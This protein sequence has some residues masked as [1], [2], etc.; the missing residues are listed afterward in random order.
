MATFYPDWSDEKYQGYLREFNL[1]ETK[2]VSELSAGMKVKFSI[3]LALSHGAELLIM[4]EPTSGLDPLSREEFCDMVLSLK[5]D[6]GIT[7]LFSTHITSD[8]MRIADDII[9]IS[10][11]KVM[12]QEDLSSLI[13]KY[14][15]IHF[16][17]KS[18]APEDK[19]LIGLKKV[20]D[21]YAAL[22]DA[23]E[24]NIEGSSATIDDIIIHLEAEKNND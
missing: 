1:D 22:I 11:G 15:L 8:L 4:D 2:K 16:A 10:D 3:T 12:L 24:G 23:K 5:Q 14:R 9:Y 13:N 6:K 18:L 7:V 20:K 21:G 17:D 19:K